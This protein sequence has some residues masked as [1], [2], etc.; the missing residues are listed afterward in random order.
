MQGN[1]ARWSGERKSFES[2]RDF[3]KV[4]QQKG[5]TQVDV[6]ALVRDPYDKLVSA[7]KSKIRCC[8]AGQGR[9]DRECGVDTKDRDWMVPG[10]LKLARVPKQKRDPEGCLSTTNLFAMVVQQ[11]YP[12][13]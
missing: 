12:Q 13:A 4:L 9:L 11:V 3:E 1:S 7:W 2:W 6:V 5:A 8:V 10:L